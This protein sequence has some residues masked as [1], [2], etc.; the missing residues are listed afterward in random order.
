MKDME[1]I[2]ELY[3]GIKLTNVLFLVIKGLSL[4]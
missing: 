2:F 3:L 1:A 4:A